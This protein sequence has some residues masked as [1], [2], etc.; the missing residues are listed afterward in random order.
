MLEQKILTAEVVEAEE[1]AEQRLGPKAPH[2]ENMK[3]LYY[4][5]RP[6]LVEVE[7][8]MLSLHHEY[9][10]IAGPVVRDLSVRLKGNR[11]IITDFFIDDLHDR[12]RRIH[13]QAKELRILFDRQ[14]LAA[15]NIMRFV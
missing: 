11:C 13:Q 7:R 12:S 10:S 1:E 6:L 9:M 3:L 2:E 8:S 14:Q 4:R 15:I 5:Y